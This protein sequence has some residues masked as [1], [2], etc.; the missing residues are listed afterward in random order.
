MQ[1]SNLAS[2]CESCIGNKTKFT[3]FVEVLWCVGVPGIQ[4]AR[5]HI[6][7]KE[8]S[9]SADRVVSHQGGTP[10]FYGRILV[11]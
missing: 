5:R 8:L 3:F 9:R 11:I 2:E 7:I 10:V 6:I 4:P 1:N